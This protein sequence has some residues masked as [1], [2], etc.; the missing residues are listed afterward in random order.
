[1]S[2][3]L[4]LAE[5]VKF[6]CLGLGRGVSAGRSTGSFGQGREEGGA[7]NQCVHEAGDFRA[8][9]T[10]KSASEMTE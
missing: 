8:E 4:S 5:Q 7:G 3:Y 10:H 1:M 9:Q 6:P 2:V